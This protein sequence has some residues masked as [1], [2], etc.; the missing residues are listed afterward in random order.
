M[1]A[2]SPEHLMARGYEPND[3]AP[4]GEIWADYVVSGGPSVRVILRD[5]ETEIISFDRF[6]VLDWKVVLSGGAP[7]AVTRS[8]LDGAEDAALAAMGR[9]K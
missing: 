3:D 7:W 9:H 4:V 5:G 1:F 8:V 6:T 2:T